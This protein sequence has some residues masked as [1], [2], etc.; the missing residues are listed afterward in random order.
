MM[1]VTEALHCIGC[2]TELGFLPAFQ[3]Q[4]SPLHCPRCQSAQLDAFTCENGVLVDCRLC[5]GQFVS[6]PVLKSLVQRHRAAPA[7]SGRLRPCNP[8]KERVTYLACPSCREFMHR[9]NFG[10]ISGV[11]VD[12]CAI[13]GTW[14]DVGELARILAFVGNGGLTRSELIKAEQT[15]RVTFESPA[16]PQG[17][18]MGKSCY[19]EA[20]TWSDMC[21]AAAA[22]A[23]WALQLLR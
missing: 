12:V 13:H 21:H 20:E 1:N 6:H 23:R 5:G 8:L 11:V 16:Q 9:R 3:E 4:T 7:L 22:F 18:L 15:K 14:F 17:I 2:G 19:E 10:A